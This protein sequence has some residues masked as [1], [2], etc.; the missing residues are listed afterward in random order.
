[1]SKKIHK[2][3]GQA[4]PITA[5]GIAL[6]EI[7]KGVTLHVTTIECLSSAGAPLTVAQMKAEVDTITIKAGS[8]EIV[9]N[10][11][12]TDLLELE[13]YW[14]LTNADGY[15]NI[16]HALPYMEQYANLQG[17]ALDREITAIGT[18]DSR[19]ITAQV[20]LA[21]SIPTVAQIN[22]LGEVTEDGRNFGAFISYK[23][24]NRSFATASTEQIDELPKGI[25]N[26]AHILWKLSK[27]TLTSMN[28]KVNGRDL[29]EDKKLTLLQAQNVNAGRVAVSG[30]VHIDFTKDNTLRLQDLLAQGG[31]NE[32]RLDV[33]WSTGPTS[34]EILLVQLEDIDRQ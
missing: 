31:V 7:P 25:A 9:N 10:I 12:A 20:K 30:R 23:K 17:N 27:A 21:S 5:S 34:Y 14:G 22:I 16:Y 3:H 29:M 15:I 11:S 6:A 1:M 33:V 26:R 28:L 8:R 24:E 4:S 13:A 18:M 19:Q 2:L 32:Q